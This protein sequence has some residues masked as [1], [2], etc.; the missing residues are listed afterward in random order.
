MSQRHAERPPCRYVC[1][2]T[3]PLQSLRGELPFIPCNLM[4]RMQQHALDGHSAW[5][6]RLSANPQFHKPWRTWIAVCRNLQGS[7]NDRE[8]CCEC[9]IHGRCSVPA[10]SYE[11][12]IGLGLRR[13]GTCLEHRALD[14]R[15]S[16]LPRFPA[17]PKLPRKA[18][19]KSQ[20][21][22]SSRAHS[23][24]K[25]GCCHAVDRF[26]LYTCIADEIHVFGSSVSS[27]S[28]RDPNALKINRQCCYQSIACW[29]LH[30]S[31]RVVNRHYTAKFLCSNVDCWFA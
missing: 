4:T 13:I 14:S 9:A 22:P 15:G 7:I 30:E 19:A 6:K 23:A 21:L 27:S 11:A 25:F 17:P 26:T 10:T 3:V 31:A 8:S 16:S 12:T 1:C 20:H 29:A 5:T 24:E 2:S 28:V 18:A